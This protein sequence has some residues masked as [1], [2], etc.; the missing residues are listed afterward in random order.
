MISLELTKNRPF[1]VETPDGEFL[2]TAP[3]YIVANILQLHDTAV[4]WMVRECVEGKGVCVLHIHSSR[5]NALTGYPIVHVWYVEPWRRLMTEEQA[6][7][8]VEVET[9]CAR[10]DPRDMAEL[11][12]DQMCTR[13]VRD[14][15][16]EM[17]SDHD[18]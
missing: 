12:L 16:K 6:Q 10:D 8:A 17:E 15:I 2:F 13:E 7:E 11:W 4:R 1:T 14:Y 5:Y 9:E 3:Q 18:S